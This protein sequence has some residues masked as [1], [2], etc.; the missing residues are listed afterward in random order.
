M[1]AAVSSNEESS[2]MRAQ[3]GGVGDDFAQMEHNQETYFSIVVLEPSDDTENK[4]CSDP[5][6]TVV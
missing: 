3:G 5:T 1:E 2:P 4:L 6:N